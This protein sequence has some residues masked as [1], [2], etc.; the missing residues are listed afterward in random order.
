MNKNEK[1]GKSNEKK[2]DGRFRSKHINHDP[3]AESTRA[4]FG[5]DNDRIRNKDES[6]Q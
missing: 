3:N 6:T 2:A 5:L 1:K 4:V